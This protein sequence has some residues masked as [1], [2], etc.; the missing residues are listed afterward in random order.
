[1][2]RRATVDGGVDGADKDV[3]LDGLEQHRVH[4]EI[5][6]DLVRAMRGDEDQRRISPARAQGVAQVRSTH[7]RHPHVDDQAVLAPGWRSLEEC[8]PRLERLDAE[9]RRDEKASESSANGVIVVDHEHAAAARWHRAEGTTTGRRKDMVTKSN[10]TRSP[11]AV[12]GPGFC[13]DI[14]R[15]QPASVGLRTRTGGWA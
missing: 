6:L 11:G 5:F 1:M 8:R 14:R 4:R 7:A 15:V 3:R 9:T 2:T 13:P 12:A 10:M